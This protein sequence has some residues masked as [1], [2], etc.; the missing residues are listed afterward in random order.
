MMERADQNQVVEVGSSAVPPPSNV[1][2]VRESPSSTTGEG[3]LLVAVAELSHHPGRGLARHP[4]Q[5]D[6]VARAILEHGLHSP[7]AE[8]SLE[9]LR[10]DRGSTFDLPA[11]ANNRH[12]AGWRRPT[13]TEAWHS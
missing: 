9:R 5:T 8:Q 13:L 10:M 11:A 1:V 12:V 2:R 3:A 7:V 6:H 4:P